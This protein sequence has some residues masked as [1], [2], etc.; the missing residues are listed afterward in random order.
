MLVSGA[1]ILRESACRCSLRLSRS[2]VYP[3]SC[4][5]WFTAL[6]LF[7]NY[8]L[9]M[10]SSCSETQWRRIVQLE[11]TPRLVAAS[12]ASM[13]S[14]LAELRKQPDIYQSV[15]LDA[16]WDS[17]RNGYFCTSLVLDYNTGYVGFMYLMCLSNFYILYSLVVTQQTISKVTEKNSWKMETAVARNVFTDLREK[18]GWLPQEVI[19]D[20][21]Q[22]VR[23]YLISRSQF[24]ELIYA[25]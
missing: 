19:H 8:V 2:C 15:S 10:R 12:N 20:D 22:K 16:R 4:F 1:L 3:Y 6:Y 13:E 9:T 7:M 5:C 21:N 24:I 18:H 23:V 17:S 14:A 25:L 11:I